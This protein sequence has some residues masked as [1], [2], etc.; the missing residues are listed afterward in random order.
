LLLMGSQ[1]MPAKVVDICAW[2]LF[3]K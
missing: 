1:V 2:V 3:L